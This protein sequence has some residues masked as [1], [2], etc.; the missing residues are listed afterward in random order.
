MVGNHLRKL[1]KSRFGKLGEEFGEL[2]PLLANPYSPA[3]HVAE[4][5]LQGPPSREES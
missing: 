5:S 2:E 4:D 3:Q 1:R